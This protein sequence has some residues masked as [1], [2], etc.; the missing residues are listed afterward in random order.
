VIR[1]P[2]ELSKFEF[3]VLASLRSVQL[4]RGCIPRVEGVHKRTVIAQMEVA[5]G[6]VARTPSLVDVAREPI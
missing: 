3:V 5:S 1:P 2:A 4:T 6:L